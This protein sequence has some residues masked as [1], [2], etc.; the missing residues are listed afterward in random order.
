MFK[1]I[2]KAPYYYVRPCPFCKSNVTG[3]F[4]KLRRDNVSD[5]QINEA[6]RHGEIVKPIEEVGNKNCFCLNC[7]EMW[8]DT[9]EMKLLTLKEI[10]N[11]K[12]LRRTR[13]LLNRRIYEERE[14]EK[15]DH[16]IFKPIKKF[17]GKL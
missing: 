9:V 13:E 17:I 10:E 11:E 12:T 4:I 14:A 8:S 6:L 7:Q 15:K 3:Y 16:S 2:I 5:W 1:N